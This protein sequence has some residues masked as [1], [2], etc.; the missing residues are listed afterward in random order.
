MGP[1]PG[2]HRGAVVPQLGQ[3]LG[4]RVGVAGQLHRGGVGQQA[5]AAPHRP[6]DG[7]DEE[8]A[9]EHVGEAVG[10]GGH[11]ERELHESQAA[12]G[13][14]VVQRP[15]HRQ[16]GQVARQELLL[17][18]VA[19]PRPPPEGQ[20]KCAPKRPPCPPAERGGE[21]GADHVEGLEGGRDDQRHPQVAVDHHGE[22]VGDDGARR[23]PAELVE[24]AAGHHDGD[25]TTDKDKVLK[26]QQE[27]EYVAQRVIDRQVNMLSA[28]AEETIQDKVVPTSIF[29]KRSS[30]LPDPLS[31]GCDQITE[32]SNDGNYNTQQKP[33]KFINANSSQSVCAY[34]ID[35]KYKLVISVL[36]ADFEAKTVRTSIAI[37]HNTKLINNYG[38]LLT[39]FDFPLTDN[40]QIDPDH[41]FAIILHYLDLEQEVV[42]LKLVWF[43]KGY[44][45]ERE[46][47]INYLEIRKR[48][49]R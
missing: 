47:P 5:P 27:L 22:H 3:G 46:R 42:S 13:L 33:A 43:P 34:S 24:Q 36:M 2:R 8:P 31:Y 19:P 37:Y 12:V 35:K 44:F 25:V 15:H 28:I 45:T 48:L 32:G 29:F 9:H 16:L 40:F 38:L 6:H 39:P 23:L 10:H 20:P 18:A 30:S 14:A 49:G 11:Q 17:G 41:R 1:R 26:A 4:Q 7:R 21:H